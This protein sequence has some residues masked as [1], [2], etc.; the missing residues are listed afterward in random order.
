MLKKFSDLIEELFCKKI[1]LLKADLLAQK[2]KIKEL[3]NKV[4][5]PRFVVEKVLNT[6]IK[7]FAHQDMSTESRRK[8]YHEAKGILESSAFNNTINYLIATQCQE[9]IKQYN[10]E[11]DIDPIRDIQMAI[12]AWEL[13]KEELESIPDPD[14]EPKS[15]INDFDPYAL[16]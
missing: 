6:G 11:L 10:P 7:W 9:Q 12:N 13:L 4:G 8:Y 15:K 14:S 2:E 1:A 5:D 3:E 16:T